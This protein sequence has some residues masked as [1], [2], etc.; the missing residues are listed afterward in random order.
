VEEVVQENS[1]KIENNVKFVQEQNV[2][3]GHEEEI[4]VLNTRFPYLEMM[5]LNGGESDL[6]QLVQCYL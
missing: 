1:T 4:W 5:N 3:K 6:S 2:N